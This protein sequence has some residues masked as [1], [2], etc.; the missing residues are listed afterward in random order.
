MAN[1]LGMSAEGIETSE[2]ADDL[3]ELDCDYGQG[4]LFNKPLDDQ[5]VQ[6]LIKESIPKGAKRKIRD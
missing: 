3:E 1:S 4:Y 5:A 2:Q 6:N